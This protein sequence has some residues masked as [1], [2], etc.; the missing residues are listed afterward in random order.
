[1]KKIL[2]Y[3]LMS[4]MTF[5]LSASNAK[6]QISTPIFIGEV[7]PVIIDQTSSTQLHLGGLTPLESKR[8][9]RQKNCLEYLYETHGRDNEKVYESENALA[10]WLNEERT[11]M[12][13]CG[14][15][16]VGRRNEYFYQVMMR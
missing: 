1:M 13:T 7:F 8:Y 15:F 3:G 14:K 9:R 11:F 2:S 6:S 12:A 4:L 10:V 5:V 16:D